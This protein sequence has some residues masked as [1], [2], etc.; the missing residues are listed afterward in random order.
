MEPTT[1]IHITEQ[2]ADGTWEDCT[3]AGG[4]EF[5]R[6]AFDPRKPATHTE[7][8]ALR[9][10]SGEPLT[11]G[12]N[13]GNF[14][15]GVKRRYGRDLPAAISNKGILSALRPGY[16]ATVQGS[17]SA[18]GPTNSLSKYDR[19]FDGGHNVWMARTPDGRTL[20]WCD[21]EAPTGA[22]VP[23]II[24][25]NDV[26][27]FVNAFDGL[28]IVA[29]ALKWPI[30]KE[31]TD[32]R[33]IIRLALN[34]T[35]VIKAQS[36]IRVEPL[37]AATKVRTIATDT[38]VTSVVGYVT[39]DKDPA[40]GKTDW[41][42]WLEGTAWRFTAIDNVISLKAPGVADDDG[43]TKLTQ[44]AAVLA[45][46]KADQVALDNAEAKVAEVTAALAAAPEKERERI[47]VELGKQEAKRVMDT[48]P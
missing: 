47:A 2:E 12:S 7:Y 15:V 45:Q 14:R 22:D 1:H 17:M 32:M 25:S 31:N 9:A 37:I 6:D 20:L 41:L 30:P 16:V 10:A 8:Q 24:S 21:P 44:E 5:Y 42:G 3:W 43:F 18:F 33:P 11:G 48:A 38:T 46:K 23:V 35:A 4:L 36:N 28:A 34:Y 13:L 40:N 29:P 19:N 39:G 26:Q 27:R